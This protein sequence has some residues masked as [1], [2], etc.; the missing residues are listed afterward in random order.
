MG[1]QRTYNYDTRF[2][3]VR[4]C[5]QADAA[6]KPKPAPQPAWVLRALSRVVRCAPSPL[7]PSTPP[8]KSDGVCADRSP[9]RARAPPAPPR[10]ACA[11]DASDAQQPQTDAG[12]GVPKAAAGVTKDGNNG[13]GAPR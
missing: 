1:A 11:Q 13:R 9:S 4:V 2:D 10:P 3:T 7:D 12:W 6:P 5:R 8:W